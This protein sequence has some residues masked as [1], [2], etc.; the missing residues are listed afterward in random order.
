MST[1]NPV[2]VCHRFVDALVSEGDRCIDATVGNGHDTVFLAKRV[3]VAGHV[4]GVDIQAAAV[5]QAQDRLAAHALG[6]RVSLRVS[7]HEDLAGHLEALGWQAIKLAIFN[8]GYLPGSDKS[9]IT[10]SANTIRALNTCEYFM[11]TGGAISL[12]A[13]R[14][15]DGGMEEYE[16]VKEWFAQLSLDA[17]FVLRYERWTRAGG[18]TPV[19]FWAQKRS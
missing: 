18:V 14:G 19:F 15:H 16:A 1:F 3:G 12:I 2:P 13:Y 9:I 10:L 7:G 8:L 4:L 11:E 17:F 5:T 6:D